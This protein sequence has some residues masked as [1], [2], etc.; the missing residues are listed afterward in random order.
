MDRTKSGRTKIGRMKI[1][2]MK[3]GQDEKWE[4][5]KW[6]DQNREDETFGHPFVDVSR[7]VCSLAW[8]AGVWPGGVVDTILTFSEK[9]KIC[10][11]LIFFRI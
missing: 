5:V 11:M 4:E 3:S 10:A 6:G 9:L 2:R 7:P 8:H 1:G